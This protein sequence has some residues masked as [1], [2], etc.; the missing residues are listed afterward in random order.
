MQRSFHRYVQRVLT[1]HS[2]N[3][4]AVCGSKAVLNMQCPVSLRN[5]SEIRRVFWNVVKITLLD[6]GLDLLNV[7]RAGWKSLALP[8]PISARRHQQGPTERH[9]SRLLFVDVAV[10]LY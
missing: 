6:G 5:I 2:S 7:T 4:A 8:R 10:R 3:K 1:S 9:L